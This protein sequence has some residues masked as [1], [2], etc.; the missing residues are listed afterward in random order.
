MSLTKKIFIISSSI[1]VILLLFW[2]LYVFS[3]KK[4]AP[5]PENDALIKNTTG[6]NEAIN[7]DT[8]LKMLSDDPVLSSAYSNKDN[9][10]IRYY[11]KENGKAYQI[12]L[13][14]NNKK[15]ISN[16]E[17][18]KLVNAIWSPDAEKAITV[19]SNGARFNFFYY[20]YIKKAGVP[21]KENLDTVV[22]QNG[23]RILYKYYDPQSKQ[24]TLNSS[25]PDGSNWN[26]LTSLEFRNISVAP[27]PKTS[28]VSFWNKPDAYEETVMKTV[29]II[30]GDKKTIFSGKF[31]ADYLWSPDGNSLLISNTLGKAS[32][33]LQ[34]GFTNSSG[35]EYKDLGI[36]TM[37]SKCVWSKDGKTIYYAL[38]LSIPD[39]AILPNEYES[40]I[41][42]TADT[43]WKVDIDTGKKTRLI[44]LKEM[45]ST[46]DATN[47]FLDN[48]E[49]MLFFINKKDDKLYRI[50]L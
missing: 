23:S 32:S 34:L 2:G 4:P 27:I 42:T 31:G 48:N 26:N 41:F 13:D 46:F 39:N 15:T 37:V 43:F 10:I 28:L 47:L 14:G 7:T 40:K 49:T 29:P 24:R 20:D 21:L 33:K 9:G 6:Q 50:E 22:W 16:T 38:P 11:S 19:F 18:P 35:G 17:L 5:E 25:D 8:K 3:F 44:E 45:S 30:G 12:D 36:P 1:L